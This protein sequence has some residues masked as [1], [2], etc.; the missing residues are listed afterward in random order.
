MAASRASKAL[1]IKSHQGP[2]RAEFTDAFRE[3]ARPLPGAHYLLDA[4]VAGRYQEQ[5]SAVLGSPSVLTITATEE[6]KSLERFPAYVEHL[7]SRGVRRGQPL[8]AVGGGIIQD[9]ACFLAATLLRGLEWRFYPTTLLAQAD[10]C[11]GSKSSINCGGAKNIL[12]TFTPPR[13]VGIDLAFLGTLPESDVRSGIG[14]ML[15]VH[16]IEGPKSFDRIAADYPRLLSDRKILA[17]YVLRSLR[18]KKGLIEK[19]EFDRGVRRVMNYGH[20]FGHAIEA[21]TGFAIPHGLA[22]TVG[23]DMANYVAVGLKRTRAAH[24]ARMRPVLAANYRG[25]ERTPI[26]LEGF[27]AAISKDKKNSAAA[28][29]L[30]LP[31]AAARVGLVL[32]PNDP[33]F[34]KLCGDYLA[35]GRERALA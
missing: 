12:G 30:I 33:A 5:L 35:S 2:Y 1:T 19:D 9:I 17:D 10:S 28:L 4:N 34:R 20:S 24:Y 13:R 31:D 15:K 11:I 22:V 23:M 25:F 3:L 21:A 32:V 14:E 6:A 26:P 8:I 27:L 29:G 18:I 7:V 16:A